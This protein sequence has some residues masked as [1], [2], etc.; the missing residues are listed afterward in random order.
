MQFFLNDCL[1]YF[2]RLKHHFLVKLLEYF[3]KGESYFYFYLFYL[4]LLRCPYDL[5]LSKGSALR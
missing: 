2:L 4:Q 3:D 1:C 5:K